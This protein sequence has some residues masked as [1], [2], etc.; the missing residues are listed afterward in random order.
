[1]FYIT[2]LA[3]Q[4]WATITGDHLQS[5]PPSES[6]V[7]RFLSALSVN[8][9]IA[10]HLL[11]HADAVLAASVS[12]AEPSERSLAVDRTPTQGTVV[13]GC[14][15]GIVA[16]FTGLALPLYCELVKRLNADAESQSQNEGPNL[17]PNPGPSSYAHTWM[18]LL[19]EQTRQM[20]SLAT[21]E[22]ARAIRLWGV[23]HLVP[24]Q[25]KTVCEYAKFALDEVEGMVVVDP[26]RVR[27]LQTISNQLSV[28]GYSQ[29]LFSEEETTRLIQRLDLYLDNAAQL[30]TTTEFNFDSDPT[31]MFGDLLLPLD[32]AWMSSLMDILGT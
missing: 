12:A 29:N 7:L 32:Q 8:H 22:F 23:V 1:M 24:V 31:A 15:Y 30:T 13:R 10:S 6:A 26:E 28:A 18:R 2:S 25:R 5:A 27:D 17:A 4:L 9:A 21:H 20:T 3:R 14:A 16:G 11:A 19:L